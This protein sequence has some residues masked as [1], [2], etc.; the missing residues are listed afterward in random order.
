LIDAN[1]SFQEKVFN[2]KNKIQQKLT[3]ENSATNQYRRRSNVEISEIPNSI[4]DSLLE[5]K[6]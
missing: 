1:K 4:D 6:S 5:E 3:Y 2:L